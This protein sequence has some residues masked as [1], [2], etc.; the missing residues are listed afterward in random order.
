M[1]RTPLLA[2]LLLS[3]LSVL[4]IVAAVLIAGCSLVESDTPTPSPTPDSPEIIPLPSDLGPARGSLPSFYRPHDL[5]H[6]NI[7]DTP[8]S[9][10]W[11]VYSAEI[12][13][14]A[15][16]SSAK[17]SV[18]KSRSGELWPKFTYHPKL[19]LTFDVIETLKGTSGQQITVT[20]YDD[21][22]HATEAVAQSRAEEML[23]ERDS[24]WADREAILFLEQL[25]ALDRYNVTG[26]GNVNTFVRNTPIESRLNY[27]AGSDSELNQ[28]EFSISPGWHPVTDAAIASRSLVP[29]P[30]MLWTLEEIR[31]SESLQT[32]EWTWSSF[33]VS[34][35][36][37][38]IERD[39]AI[40]G[41]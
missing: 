27:L 26:A 23:S 13:M 9:L 11:Q 19:E 17:A 21:W 1:T 29:G 24:R 38:E 35:I 31:W 7:S 10:D 40:Y 16:F 28:S 3:M 34:D 36:L 30:Y 37:E 4:A 20:V 39:L 18:E 15:R 5:T 41:R 22:W 8:P 25:P 6:T 32:S 2:A 33:T 14:R 12:I